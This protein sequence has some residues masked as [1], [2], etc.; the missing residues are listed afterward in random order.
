MTTLML[1][2]FVATLIPYQFAYLVACMVQIATCIRALRFARENV[3]ALCALSIFSISNW[4]LG[5]FRAVRGVLGFLPLR[6]LYPCSHALDLTNQSPCSCRMGTQFNCSL[7]YTIFVSSQFTLNYAIYPACG[8][9]YDREH[10]SSDFEPVFTL[11]PLFEFH[12][13]QGSD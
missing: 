8:N 4:R 3:Y 7:A 10:D 2:F 9:P 13:S 12:S 11:D 5:V 6:T 1:L